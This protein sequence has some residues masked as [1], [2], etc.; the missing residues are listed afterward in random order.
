[1]MKRLADAESSQ[2]QAGC[3]QRQV[4]F[5]QLTEMPTRILT[6]RTDR[7]EVTR[8]MNR[9][10]VDRKAA[11]GAGNISLDDPLSKFRISD[12]GVAEKIRIKHSLTHTSGLGSYFNQKFTE[13]SRALHG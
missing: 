11:F 13:S 9:C 4:L 6:R 10:Y 5:K 8:T 3:S 1:M 7:H 2:V 12:K